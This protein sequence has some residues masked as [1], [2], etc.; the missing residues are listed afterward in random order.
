MRREDK[1]GSAAE[2]GDVTKVNAAPLHTPLHT[3]LHTHPPN[4]CLAAQLLA[5][6]PTC[7]L[8][9]RSLTHLLTHSLTHSLTDSLTRSLTRSIA[10][11]LTRSLTH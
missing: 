7:L 5:H 1:L 3:H 4:S 10:H 2:E 9:T 8:L 11:S 6:S